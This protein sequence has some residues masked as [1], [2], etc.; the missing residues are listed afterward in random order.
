MKSTL[1]EILYITFLLTLFFQTR[2][3]NA[4]QNFDVKPKYTTTMVPQPK[5]NIEKPKS[6]PS[7]SIKKSN[8][9]ID[10]LQTVI[11]QYKTDYT[12]ALRLTKS[13]D[14]L[15]TEMDQKILQLQNSN[16]DYARKL[17]SYKGENLKLDQSNRILIIFN[18]IVG[19]LLLSTLVWF[20]RNIAKKKPA[21]NTPVTPSYE[22]TSTAEQATLAAAKTNHQYFENK[23]EQLEKLGK[24]K[25]RGILT[26]E[27]FNKQ[28]QQVL[29]SNL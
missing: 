24:L 21:N 14:S 26:D 20:L 16:N 4:Q 29:G 12:A 10:S 2:W 7:V 25:E 3:L 17:S 5:K 19:V 18:S 11:D 23:L 1:K 22:M 13:K 8:L 15:L 6:V 27:E 28:K 9:E